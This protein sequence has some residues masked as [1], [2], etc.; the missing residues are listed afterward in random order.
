MS[1]PP[2]LLSHLPAPSGDGVLSLLRAVRPDV[3]WTLRTGEADAAPPAA[4]LAAGV[5][6]HSAG[7]P[8]WR[9]DADG[10]WALP[11]PALFRPVSEAPTRR[12]AT[13]MVVEEGDL[14]AP[15]ALQRLG[16][17]VGAILRAPADPAP[18]PAEL[19]Q[20]DA[21]V[22]GRRETAI[23]ANALLK[24]AVLVDA[25][26]T[27]ADPA[28]PFTLAVAEPEQVADLLNGMD[29]AALGPELLNWKRRVRH[30]A[31]ARMA[32]LAGSGQP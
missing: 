25:G 15:A 10:G 29:M 20:A 7:A 12:L 5:V 18:A 28:L 19:A 16:P 8:V 21:V 32:A 22:C 6:A 30:A 13:V 9:F 17:L 1:T 31:E 24:P 27:G 14:S 4:V 2:F 11:D 23:L 3:A 26:G